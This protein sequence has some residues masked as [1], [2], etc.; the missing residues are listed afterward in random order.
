MWSGCGK[1][2]AKSRKQKNF[3]EFENL[4]R[5]QFRSVYFLISFCVNNQLQ[6]LRNLSKETT[7]TC[8][9]R[10]FCISFSKFGI[11][12][13]EEPPSLDFIGLALTL[14]LFS[15][16]FMS[17]PST[18]GGRMSFA[19][20]TSTW[21]FT[22][23]ISCPLLVSQTKSSLL[24]S[25]TFERFFVASFSFSAP[26]RPVSLIDPLPWL[27]FLLLLWSDPLDLPPLDLLSEPLERRLAPDLHDSTVSFASFWLELW[28]FQESLDWYLQ[29][30]VI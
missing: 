28:S 19:M 22:S 15:S 12:P 2:F 6:V 13:Y 3:Q 10:I 27:F 16:S 21:L 20:F 14:G 4:L 23:L 1:K 18:G 25:S 7:T 17:P 8:S 5:K 11:G 9:A 24:I 26:E 29:W 30:N